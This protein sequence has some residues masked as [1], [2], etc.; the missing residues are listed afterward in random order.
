MTQSTTPPTP[1]EYP[2]RTPGPEE[3]GLR[4]D[5]AP[6][7]QQ[8]AM[9]EVVSRPGDTSRADEPVTHLLSPSQAYDEERRTQRAALM[10]R[11]GEEIV[12]WIKTFASAAV[13]ATLIVTFG[14]QVAR[15]EGKSMEPTLADQDRLIVN[16]ALYQFFGVPQPGDIV[17]L[18]YP[19]DPDKSFVKRVIAGEGDTVRI[20]DG[21]VYVNE[22]MLSDEYVKPDYR[23]HENHG[24]E[25]VQEAHYFVMGDNRNNSS[26]SRLWGQVPEKYVIGK[27]YLRW[28]P[29]TTAT[30][31]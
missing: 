17:M 31:F 28:W 8:A 3:P 22:V 16:K 15:V 9:D 12:A 24:P 20:E 25:V 13:Y 19:R 23:S 4:L 1:E 14:F 7:G 6:T 5:T 18:Y 26:D 10:A 29:L 30:V 21:R 11:V 27:V 2:I